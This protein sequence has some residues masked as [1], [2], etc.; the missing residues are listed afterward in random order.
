MSCQ[1]TPSLHL[2]LGASLFVVKTHRRN[3]ISQLQAH[4]D[5]IG[6]S[7]RHSSRRWAECVLLEEMDQEDKT[8]FPSN[9]C[10][11]IANMVKVTFLLALVV[12]VSPAAE[13]LDNGLALTPTMGWLHWE[14]FMCNIDCDTDPNN[15]IR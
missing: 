14:R 11:H 12:S 13:A 4:L 10:S 7:I 3:A 9:R 6:P 8:V 2:N 15:C 5:T 1:L